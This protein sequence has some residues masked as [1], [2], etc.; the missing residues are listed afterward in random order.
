ML[1]TKQQLCKWCSTGFIRLRLFSKHNRPVIEASGFVQNF[2]LIDLRIAELL[3]R[4][5]RLDLIT[6]TSYSI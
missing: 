3:G 2:E 5:Q 1:S 6:I 4:V